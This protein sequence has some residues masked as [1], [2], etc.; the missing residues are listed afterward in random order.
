MPCH[1][2]P[3][4]GNKCRGPK[5][6][7]SVYCALHKCRNQG[8]IKSVTGP[9]TWWCQGHFKC[10]TKGC[11]KLKH[12]GSNCC[13]A[14]TC[15]DAQCSE[16]QFILSKFCNGHKCHINNCLSR[17]AGTH[18]FCDRHQCSMK[19]C[20]SLKDLNSGRIFCDTHNCTAPDCLIAKTGP[21]AACCE[22]HARGE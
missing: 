4:K 8:C 18:R 1:W 2:R 15:Q 17:R 11:Q 22:G 20:S 7:G 16:I 19:G 9:D 10:S 13:T 12:K 14:H 21:G 5:S 3:Q 6:P